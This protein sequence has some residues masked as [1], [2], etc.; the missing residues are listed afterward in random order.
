MTNITPH[1]LVSGGE[2]K[3]FLGLQ[4]KLRSA[5][6]DKHVQDWE[7]LDLVRESLGAILELEKKLNGNPSR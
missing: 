4:N 7:L 2:A 5:I 3:Y 6:H 1:N